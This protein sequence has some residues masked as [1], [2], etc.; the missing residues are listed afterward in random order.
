MCG[1][2]VTVMMDKGQTWNEGADSTVKR[3]A[4]FLFNDTGTRESYI[5]FFVGSVRCV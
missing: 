4:L 3:E 1:G 5:I 2:G